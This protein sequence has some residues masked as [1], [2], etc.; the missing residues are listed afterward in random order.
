VNT[1]IYSEL[2]HVTKE[3]GALKTIV[4]KIQN[5]SRKNSV[6]SAT[7]KDNKDDK[8]GKNGKNGQLREEEEKLTSSDDEMDEEVALKID[9]VDED[10]EIGEAVYVRRSFSGPSGMDDDVSLKCQPLTVISE[11]RLY[12]IVQI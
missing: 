7:Q 4:L 1:D 3:T 10:P 5:A 2:S 11:Y 8:S 12:L 6:R 9:S